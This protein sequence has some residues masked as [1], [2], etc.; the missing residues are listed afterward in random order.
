MLHIILSATAFV[1]YMQTGIFMLWKNRKS[2]INRWFFVISAYLA[3]AAVLLTL[4]SSVIKHEIVFSVLLRASW[5]LVPAFLFRFH[6][7]LSGVPTSK[8]IQDNWFL[9][10]LFMGS[11]IGLFMLSALVTIDIDRLPLAA[12]WFGVKLFWNYLFHAMI[13]SNLLVILYQYHHWRKQIAWR[14]ERR[15]FLFVTYSIIIPGVFVSLLES[16]APGMPMAGMLK[17]P[18]IFMLPWFLI[19]AYGF[20]HYK[21]S[22]PDPAKAASIVLKDLRQ[23]LFFCNEQLHLTQMN[24]YAQKVL[25]Y[26]QTAIKG[27]NISELFHDRQM[28]RRLTEE[29]KSSGHAGPIEVKLVKADGKQVSVSVSCVLLK[30]RFNDVYG[31]AFYGTDLSEFD[32]LRDEIHKREQIETKLRNISDD[33][34][35]EAMKRSHEIR[36]SLEEAEQKMLERIKAEELIKAEL[37]EIE[38]MM[39][40]IHS[41]NKKNLSL[42]L[43]LLDKSVKQNLTKNETQQIHSLYQRINSILIVNTKINTLDRYGMVRFKDFLEEI[44]DIYAKAGDIQA[45]IKLNTEEGLLWIDQAIPLALVSNELISNAFRH[46]FNDM[47]PDN[48]C[49]EITYIHDGNRRCSLEVKDNGRGFKDASNC[50]RHEYS[51]LHL[52]QT[53]VTDQLSGSIAIS[54]KGG[55]AIVVSIPLDQLRQ[56]HMGHDS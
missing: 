32:A 41:R 9:A 19:V 43:S 16:F 8:T 28:V 30:D 47:S 50:N 12:Q 31:M 7:Y 44:V 40:E 52:A 23:M 10:F 29:V 56:G 24:A 21:F 55:T 37:A 45:E 39:G 42:L 3:L 46:A 34:E 11:I 26:E 53:L 2:P 25:K 6:T 38:I 18:H 33:L 17:M 1:L 36:H 49:I 22:P 14:K 13:F 4:S 20:V 54:R 27:L 5:C 35:A 15:E 51:G 48:A